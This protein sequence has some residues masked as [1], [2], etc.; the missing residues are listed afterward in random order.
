MALVL[1]AT[2]GATNANTY[3]LA[4]D[5]D[6]LAGELFPEP[7]AWLAADTE[8]QARALVTATRLL[9]ELGWPG[10]RVTDTQALAWPRTDVR[11]PG[12]GGLTYDTTMIPA[13]VVWATARLAIW[14]LERPAGEDPLAASHAG[15]SSLSLGSEL[16]LSFEGGAGARSPLALFLDQQIRPRLGGLAWAAQP[17]MVRG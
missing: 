4:A 8:T 17:R 2:A 13:A 15:L 10:K 9:D 11:R 16:S 7:T 1:V 5:A 6:T 12:P 14:L 3:A